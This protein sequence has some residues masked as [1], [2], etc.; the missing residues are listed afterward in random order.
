MAQHYGILM[1][2]GRSLHNDFQSNK[3]VQVLEWRKVPKM[4]NRRWDSDW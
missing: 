2:L 4:A 3:Y 1:E